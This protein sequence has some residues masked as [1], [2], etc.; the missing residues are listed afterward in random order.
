[1][2]AMI[3]GTQLG[4]DVFGRGGPPIILVH[5]FGLNRKIWYPVVKEYLHNQQVILP[6][7][8]GH[9]E[10]DAPEG[11]YHMSLL[12]EDLLNLMA[13]LSIDRAIICGHSMGGYITLAFA[14]A[15]PDLMSGM[16]LITTR[17]GAD[18]EKGRAGR[19]E[20]ID[21]VKKEGP[22]AL[23]DSLAPRL[24]HDEALV[25]EMRAMLAET[26]PAGIIG[27]QKGMAQRPDRMNLLPEITVP[28]LVVAGGQDQIVDI[29]EA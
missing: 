2:K 17:A 7:V 26:S 19:Y 25:Q 20:S 10:S 6:D 22:T 4:Y 23:A 14:D 24:T 27:A 13:F 12:A 28:S 8:R 15:Y 5:G 11:A 1:M 3:N 16:G 21:A 9:G 18:T 29:Q